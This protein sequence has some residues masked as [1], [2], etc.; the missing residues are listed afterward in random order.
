MGTG[1]IRGNTIVNLRE[2]TAE[3]QLQLKETIAS[4]LQHN[5]EHIASATQAMERLMN[6]MKDWEI[7]FKVCCVDFGGGVAQVVFRWCI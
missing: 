2:L 3:F 4:M 1:G 7:I 5:P 6:N